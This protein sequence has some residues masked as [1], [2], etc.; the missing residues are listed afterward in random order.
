MVE[1]GPTAPERGYPGLELC[2]WPGLHEPALTGGDRDVWGL[3]E[4]G[5]FRAWVPGS[6]ESV[7]SHPLTPRAQ[8]P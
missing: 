4:L 6:P 8:S 7:Y 1:S 2:Q 3:W 5:Q